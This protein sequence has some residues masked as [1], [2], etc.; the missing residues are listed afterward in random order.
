M[1]RLT[2]KMLLMAFMLVSAATV[3]AQIKGKAAGIVKSNRDNT[4]CIFA[5]VNFHQGSQIIK[6]TT[7]DMDGRFKISSLDT[8]TYQ[9]S[10]IYPGHDTFKAQVVVASSIFEEPLY[11]LDPKAKTIKKTVLKGSGVSG[12]SA[13]TIT[14]RR[15]GAAM[16]E[17]IGQEAI[18]Q[19]PGTTNA[20]DVLK[21]L[22]GASIQN[23]KF[24]VIRGL[25]DRYNFA[26]INGAPLPSSE[27]DK[28]RSEERREGKGGKGGCNTPWLPGHLMT[29]QKQSALAYDCRLWYNRM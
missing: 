9:I 23:N 1:K 20:G 19:A 8:G 10:I 12:T 7:T 11:N 29:K 24:A 17:I 28:K 26:L 25:S 13:R 15:E 21:K 3:N 22:T 16:M 14:L 27:A 18:K 6:R 2:I 5:K 4:T